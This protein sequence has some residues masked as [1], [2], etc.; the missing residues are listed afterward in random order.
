MNSSGAISFV[1]GARCVAFRNSYFF[2]CHLLKKIR[3]FSWRSI[4]LLTN[5]RGK[6]PIRNIIR[7]FSSGKQEKMVQ[8]CLS[9]LGLSGDKVRFLSFVQYL[10]FCDGCFLFFCVFFVFWCGCGRL[11]V[12]SV[13]AVEYCAQTSWKQ[14][15]RHQCGY[16]KTR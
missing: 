2:L 14:F 12:N 7:T 6:I 15:V 13:Y 8:K 3:C 9:D 4:C 10:W 11:N 16:W 1:T 5:E